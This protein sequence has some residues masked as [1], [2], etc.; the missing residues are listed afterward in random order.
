[1]ISQQLLQINSL[2]CF[3]KLTHLILSRKL[4]LRNFSKILANFLFFLS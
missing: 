3:S 4:A 1:M 2:D